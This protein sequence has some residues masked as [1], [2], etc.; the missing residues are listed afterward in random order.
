MLLYKPPE[1]FPVDL[2]E[3]FETQYTKKDDDEPSPVDHIIQA[4]A[5]AN[6]DWSKVCSV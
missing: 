6:V 1:Q 2:N 3:G 4:A 5:A